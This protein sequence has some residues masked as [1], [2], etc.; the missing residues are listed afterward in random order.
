[1]TST[2]VSFAA[3]WN[4][5]TG[6]CGNETFIYVKRLLQAL[7]TLLLAS[8]RSRF[9]YS[10]RRLLRYSGKP[11]KISPEQFQNSAAV[12]F[13]ALGQ[14]NMGGG[15]GELLL[16]DFGT[17]FVYQ[18]ALFL[19]CCGNSALLLAIASLILTWAIL[20]SS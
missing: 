15:C 17:S 11:S 3:G 14:S 8:R 1:V 19:R 16:G 13:V 18:L 9:H 7:L 2:R 5:L 4:W 10:T 12:Q 20:Y 6:F